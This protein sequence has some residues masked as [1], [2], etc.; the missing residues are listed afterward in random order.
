[1]A[2]VA[3]VDVLSRFDHGKANALRCAANFLFLIMQVP[4]LLR[5]YVFDRRVSGF[6]FTRS[7]K[8]F[9]HA[10]LRHAYICNA[11]F[12]QRQY[13]VWREKK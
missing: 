12:S 5:N 3:A 11:K 13:A 1:M 6:Y 9:T 10:P 8:S 2:S 7:N 4:F